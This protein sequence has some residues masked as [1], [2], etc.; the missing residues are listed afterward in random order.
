M[1]QTTEEALSYLSDAGITATEE[2]SGQ[3]QKPM[4]EIA[5]ESRMR[6]EAQTQI[7]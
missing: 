1:P 5:V 6:Q 3:W 4:A 2:R 7:E